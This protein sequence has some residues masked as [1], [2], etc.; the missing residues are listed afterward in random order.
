MLLKIKFSLTVGLMTVSSSGIRQSNLQPAS[1]IKNEMFL[2]LQIE[3]DANSSYESGKK[4]QYMLQ[5]RLSLH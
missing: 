4:T 1:V 5:T 2:P 3:I